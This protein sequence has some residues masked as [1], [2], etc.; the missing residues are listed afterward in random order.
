M[1][2]RG[3]FA[4]FVSN[5]FCNL[6]MYLIASISMVVVLVSTPYFASAA[7]LSCLEGEISQWRFGLGHAGLVALWFPMNVPVPKDDEQGE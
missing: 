1:E 2:K 4:S 7:T 3:C 6:R 5:L